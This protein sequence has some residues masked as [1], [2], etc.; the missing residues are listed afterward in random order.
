MGRGLRDRTRH[1]GGRPHKERITFYSPRKHSVT[2]DL[3]TVAPGPV[4]DPRL[5]VPKSPCKSGLTPSLDLRSVSRL[6]LHV[7]LHPR[8]SYVSPHTSGRM[9]RFHVVATMVLC[10][11][12][13]KNLPLSNFGKIRVHE[14]RLLALEKHFLLTIG[15]EKSR[16]LQRLTR[17]RPPPGRV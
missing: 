7:D 15:L 4:K 12:T 9:P 5:T 1:S 10:V 13:E 6:D 11:A 14:F 16:L 17:G 3:R 2:P 8:K